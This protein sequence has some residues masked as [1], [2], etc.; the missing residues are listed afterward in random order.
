[1]TIGLVSLRTDRLFSLPKAQVFLF[2]V[3]FAHSSDNP[4]RER[5]SPIPSN[6]IP[7]LSMSK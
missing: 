3:C 2:F 1:M 4:I 6:I 7:D 5:K